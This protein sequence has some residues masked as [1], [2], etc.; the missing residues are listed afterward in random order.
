MLLA[1]LIQAHAISCLA[2]EMAGADK[3]PKQVLLVYGDRSN[4]LAFASL[5]LDVDLRCRMRSQ[6]AF[7]TSSASGADLVVVLS[8]CQGGWGQPPVWN[9]SPLDRLGDAR[10]LACGDAG[11][12]LLQT[13]KL[14]I[15]HPHG[16]HWT[17]SRVA[18]TIPAAVLHGEARRLVEVPHDISVGEA[19]ELSIT[20][21]VA[22]SVGEHIGIFDGGEFPSGTQGV[23]RI[24]GERHHWLIASQGNYTLWGAGTRARDLTNIG[25]KL[26]ANLCWRLAHAKPEPLIFPEKELV[27]EG[28]HRGTLTG[29]GRE[30]RYL[31]IDRT[32]RLVIR[33]EWR[34]AAMMMLM[35]HDAHTQRVDGRSPL[36]IAFDVAEN[37]RG[38]ELQ[39]E[40][41]S[42]QLREGEKCPFDL[43]I[44]WDD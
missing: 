24:N 1:I 27:D 37:M 28:L 2:T 26:F 44:D 35:T 19:E 41:G 20:L 32:G 38:R 18:A 6:D 21:Q 5:L 15:G 36:E 10:V 29:G 14:L 11:A 3:S 22:D 13:K 17:G 8:C 23:G 39:I 12:S 16:A 31:S 9:G 33:L 40:V 4:A 30:E 42:F 7:A 43:T 34:S 25:Q